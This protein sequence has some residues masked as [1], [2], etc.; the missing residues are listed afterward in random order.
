MYIVSRLTK[1]I[2]TFEKKITIWITF[3]KNAR[4]FPRLPPTYVDIFLCMYIY[5]LTMCCV[6]YVKIY[7]TLS[8]FA[9]RNDNKKYKLQIKIQILY[10]HTHTITQI[11][12]YVFRIT[13]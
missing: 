5:I 13:K 6:V 1:Y 2:V 4:H 12:M 9:I 3:N 8:K 11:F 7:N 10:R